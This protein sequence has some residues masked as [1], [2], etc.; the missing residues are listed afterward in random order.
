MIFINEKFFCLFIFVPFHFLTLSPSH[1]LTFLPYLSP[2]VSPSHC[3]TFSLLK[4][5][6]IIKNDFFSTFGVKYESIGSDTF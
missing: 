5:C 3:L 6:D 1:Y 2:T 4:I